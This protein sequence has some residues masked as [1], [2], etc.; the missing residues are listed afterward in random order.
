MSRA[1]FA[2]IAHDL[3]RAASSGGLWL[4]IAFFLM[5]I[6][7]APFAIG[8][9]REF[10]ARAGTGLV[11]LAA[12]L[13][14][15]MT[16]DRMFQIDLETGL[17]DMIAKSRLGLELAVPAKIIAHWLVTG[18][19]LV[20]LAPVGGVL[21]GVPDQAG[22]LLTLTLLLGTP[23]LSAVGAIAASLTAGLRRGGLLVALLTLPLAVP[24]VIFGASACL[25]AVDGV[26]A[27]AG[28][29][30]LLL[31]SALSLASV[32]VALILVPFALRSQLS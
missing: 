2:L 32:A 28:W 17:L 26:F 14:L 9:E 1:F 6:V 7:L 15:M 31:L 3:A 16:L 12:V 20:L 4:A 8:P 5:T 19:P 22:W 21:L 25:A 24:F 18:A 29:V 27:S 10:L 30:N 11:W 13:A 23:G